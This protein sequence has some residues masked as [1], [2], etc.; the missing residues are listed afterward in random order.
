MIFRY[1]AYFLHNYC[2]YLLLQLPNS[3]L[4]RR[5]VGVDDRFPQ[6]PHFLFLLQFLLLLTH[7]DPHGL[8]KLLHRC[9]QHL[10]M[11]T[12]RTAVAF[13]VPMVALTDILHTPLAVPVP[14]HR[15]KG[16]AALFAEN[17]SG[18]AV[19]RL[20][21][22]GRTSLRFQ[23]LLSLLPNVTLNNDREEV[24]VPIPLR[25]LQSLR[26]T[27]VGFRAVVD[28]HPGIG[29]LHQD[30][31]YA[32]ICPYIAPITG[33]ACRTDFSAALLRPELCWRLSPQRIEPAGDFFL[34]M[35]L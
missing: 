34:P 13:P 14:D 12:V 30:I 24:L 27:A 3:F 23:F 32:G 17:Q 9:I 26:L 11:D 19:L 33:F 5:T 6:S 21:A 35:P 7:L 28:Q 10:L 31:F 4:L 1:F 20:V 29:L 25:L 2:I 15:H 18:V 8:G 16:A 22:I